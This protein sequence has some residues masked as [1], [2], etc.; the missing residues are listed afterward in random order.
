MYYIQINNQYNSYADPE[1][2][3]GGGGGGGGDPGL[4]DIKLFYSQLN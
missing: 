3:V 2:L 1:I 4:E